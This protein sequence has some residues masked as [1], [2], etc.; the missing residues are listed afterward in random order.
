MNFY[1]RLSSYI[2]TI[3]RVR[4]CRPAYL[5]RRFHPAWR[6]ALLLNQHLPD[7]LPNLLR[8]MANDSGACEQTTVPGCA[9]TTLTALA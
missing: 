8:Q 1:D 6:Y 2:Y 5:V 4:C 3:V 9:Q 7:Q